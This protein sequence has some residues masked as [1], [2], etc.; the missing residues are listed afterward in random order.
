MNP[1]MFTLLIEMKATFSGCGKLKMP[2]ELTERD[3]GTKFKGLVDRLGKQTKVQVSL[4]MTR[5]FCRI[6]N[7]WMV[8]YHFFNSY[9]SVSMISSTDFCSYH[10][11][12]TVFT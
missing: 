7:L 9:L 5:R 3:A 12:I 2:Q 6:Q 1:L 11:R 4:R 10:T 8:W